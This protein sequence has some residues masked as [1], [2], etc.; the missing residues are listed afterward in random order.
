VNGNAWAGLVGR[1]PVAAILNAS[2][3]GIVSGFSRSGLTPVLRATGN[4]CL[5]AGGCV[6]AGAPAA[7]GIRMP[8]SYQPL[9]YQPLSYQPLS[10]LPLSYLQL[11]YLVG[12]SVLLP[13]SP[14]VVACPGLAAPSGPQGEDPP[15]PLRDL[16]W[17][18]DRIAPDILAVPAGRRV[19]L[20]LDDL[21]DLDDLDAADVLSLSAL[22]LLQRRLEARLIGTAPALLRALRP[23]LG[24]RVGLPGQLLGVIEQRLEPVQAAAP[25]GETL[26]VRRTPLRLPHPDR[27][28]LARRVVEVAERAGPAL[29]AM[30]DLLVSTVLD[31]RP[32]R[33]GHHGDPTSPL[34][35]DLR[36]R[37]LNA[38]ASAVELLATS[39]VVAS[40]QPFAPDGPAAYAPALAL[41]EVTLL[42]TICG[43]E[44]AALR[45]A[46]AGT[47]LLRRLLPGA[48]RSDRG[49]DVLRTLA[50]LRAV[51]AAAPP[52]D[53]RLPDPRPHR[54]AGSLRPASGTPDPLLAIADRT[55]L[56]ATHGTRPSWSAAWRRWQEVYPGDLGPREAVVRAMAGWG[57]RSE[58]L[59]VLHGRPGDGPVEAF[60]AG[61]WDTVEEAGLIFLAGTDRPT[62][63]YP[64]PY[65]C[66]LP[67][68]YPLPCPKPFPDLA[69]NDE[70]VGVALAML[71]ALHRR[72]GQV[73]RALA[74]QL[75][76]TFPG[77]RPPLVGYALAAAARHQRDLGEAFDTVQ[78]D[79]PRL[80]RTGPRNGLD[81]LL[82]AAARLDRA[83]GRSAG[84]RAL[85]GEL[86]ELAGELGT[87]RA[88]MLA[89]RM[90]LAV[91]NA[92]LATDRLAADHALDRL[93]SCLAEPSTEVTLGALARAET[94][95]VVAERLRPGHPEVVALATQA[96]ELLTAL[97]AGHW[98]ARARVLLPPG[99]TSGTGTRSRATAEQVRRLIGE[100]L[101]NRQICLRLN[102]SEESVEG[103]VTRLLRAHQ[104]ANRAELAARRRRSERIRPT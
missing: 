55:L 63:P 19:T 96:T 21:D 27:D 31:R 11:S 79:L 91:G 4:G 5:D 32:G 49:S 14:D 64:L 52:P 97:Q 40:Q 59:A 3:T 57:S 71:V 33:R 69:G 61:D 18:V 42:S 60:L 41:P 76:T 80:R 78:Q 89:A 53:P 68:P 1:E 17:F 83:L 101:T 37:L 25:P 65:P 73:V 24:V 51:A 102:L 92:R 85:A 9:S 29:P 2:V 74:R 87:V 82:F 50:R 93:R 13:D 39:D 66:L 84:A 28:E 90:L 99:T 8:L 22:P 54:L 43:Q 20:L 104:C 15:V 88:E 103:Y 30:L 47:R 95:V 10:Y 6:V 45:I 48:G 36:R 94:M 23:A 58:L 16:P 12:L 62:H 77:R 44:E 46:S 75:T 34:K 100:G 67:Y 7:R 26:P 86:D 98:L 35:P 72:Q 56:E 81:L 70:L 38:I